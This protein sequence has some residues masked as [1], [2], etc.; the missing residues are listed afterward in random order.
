MGVLGLRKW[1]AWEATNRKLMCLR[2]SISSQKLFCC[3][4]LIIAHHLHMQDWSL[5]D[6]KKNTVSL[7]STRN[8]KI[9]IE[10]IIKCEL[11]HPKTSAGGAGSLAWMK[12]PFTS[13]ARPNT[14]KP[15]WWLGKLWG[16][17]SHRWMMK[18]L[19][20]KPPRCTYLGILYVKLMEKTLVLV[21]TFVFCVQWFYKGASRKNTPNS[22]RIHTDRL[23]GSRRRKS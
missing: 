6:Q 20:K 15:S 8:R 12:C 5:H 23:W 10:K 18:Q 22:I 4:V 1:W 11:M 3:T 21:R 17:T 2:W 14:K 9:I 7:V 19:N 16:L 13:L